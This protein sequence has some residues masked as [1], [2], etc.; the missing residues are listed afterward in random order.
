MPR[1]PYLPRSIAKDLIKIVE[2]LI[3]ATYL[4]Q[5]L[6]NKAIIICMFILAVS[7]L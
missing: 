2:F 4:F 3:P 7:Q 1:L 5:H 6:I